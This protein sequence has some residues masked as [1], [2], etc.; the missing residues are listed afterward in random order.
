MVGTQQG[1]TLTR[2]LGSWLLQ[3]P[4]YTK[5]DVG[6]VLTLFDTWES[7]IMVTTKA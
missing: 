1:Q 6:F 7:L 5:Q 3:D 4:A 2:D